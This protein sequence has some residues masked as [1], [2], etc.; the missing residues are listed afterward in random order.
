MTLD[1]PSA[2]TLPNPL[3]LTAT[4]EDDGLPTPRKGPPTR[5]IGQ[6]TSANSQ[7]PTGPA[8]GAVQRPRGW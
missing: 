3:T 2:V 5:A 4:V 7:T 6:K 1:V 8:R